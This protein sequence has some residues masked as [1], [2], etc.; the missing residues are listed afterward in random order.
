VALGLGPRA[1]EAR[2]SERIP[3]LA[4]LARLS[5]PLKAVC[6]LAQ[7]QLSLDPVLGG[8]GAGL[9]QQLP[10]GVGLDQGV[11]ARRAQRPA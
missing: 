11:K 3:D 8:L 6:R 2:R 5:E 10:G 1:G 7:P 4:G 9:G